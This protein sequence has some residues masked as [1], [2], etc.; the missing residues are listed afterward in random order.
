MKLTYSK[1]IL[2]LSII[3]LAVV[4][5]LDIIFTEMLLSKIININEK[6][7]QLNLSS[8]EREK[9]LT[10]RESIVSSKD[11]REK[12][13]TYFVGP[14]NAETVEF[15]KYLEDL[16]LVNGVTQ[17]KSLGYEAVSELNSSNV[18]SAIR[19][20]FNVSGKWT[21]VFNFLRAIENLPKV[22]Y[23]NSVSLN[24]S[25]EAVSAKDI[26]SG[27]KIWS[28]DLDFSVIKLK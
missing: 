5:A 1:R 20:R 24:V 11:E 18:V 19:F 4:L 22:A 17:K 14:G 13:L 28:A 21:N 10:L 16:A 25:S 7:K 23:L 9:E 15:T 3:V 12:L 26:K 2:I 27:N 6:V 8:Q